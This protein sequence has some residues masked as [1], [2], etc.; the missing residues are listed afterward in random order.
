MGSQ[1]LE[2]EVSRGTGSRG[3]ARG[4]ITGERAHGALQGKWQ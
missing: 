2:A 1:L 3:C 4:Q